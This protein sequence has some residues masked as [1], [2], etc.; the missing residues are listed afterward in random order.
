MTPQH[1]CDLFPHTV[2]YVQYTR[3]INILVWKDATFFIQKLLR[4]ERGDKF[5]R[6]ESVAAGIHSVFTKEMCYKLR[7]AAYHHFKNSTRINQ[8]CGVLG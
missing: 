3:I 1:T 4:S 5:K 7:Q 8:D 6:N 2:L